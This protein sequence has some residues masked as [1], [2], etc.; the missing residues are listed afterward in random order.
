MPKDMLLNGA[1]PMK[2]HQGF[3]AGKQKTKFE[4]FILKL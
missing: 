1:S 4:E 2:P 3:S